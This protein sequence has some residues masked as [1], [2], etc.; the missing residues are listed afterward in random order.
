[1]NGIH[2]MGGMHGFG[3]IVRDDAP[4]HAPWELRARA[5]V[6]AM[7]HRRVFNVDE[8][9]R[10][11]EC[12]PPARYLA[13]GYF[14]RWLE[15]LETLLVEKGA[16]ATAEIDAAAQQVAQ[17][18]ESSRRVER[19]RSAALAHAM[20]EADRRP[21]RPPAGAET[22]RF[23]SGDRVRAKNEHVQGHT[24]LAR[25]TRGRQGT[26]HRVHGV[27]PLADSVAH[28]LGPRP[29]PVYSVRFTASELWGEAAA[30]NDCVYID[31]WESYLD[32]A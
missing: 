7:M 25:Y 16:A 11:I 27:Y 3:P 9:R 30:S 26:I 12:I 28:G 1:M 29:E 6:A 22:A 31:L 5:M 21:A 17:A 4:Y 8:L 32:P 23:R 14:E 18:R 24:R 10:A 13:S 20:I 19:P 2:D 15:A